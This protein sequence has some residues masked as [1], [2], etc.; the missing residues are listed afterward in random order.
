MCA[1]LGEILKEGFVRYVPKENMGG[2]AIY[3]LNKVA[4]W[5]QKQEGRVIMALPSCF[6]FPI[7]FGRFVVQISISFQI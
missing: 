2:P 7:S 6:K 1:V 4:K 5:S 3:L